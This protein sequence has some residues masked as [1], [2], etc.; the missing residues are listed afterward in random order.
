MLDPIGILTLGPFVYY[1]GGS[2]LGIT[3]INNSGNK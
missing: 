2:S 1:L 3:A